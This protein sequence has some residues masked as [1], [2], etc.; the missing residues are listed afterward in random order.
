[1]LTK[2]ESTTKKNSLQ[3]TEFPEYYAKDSV[4]IFYFPIGCIF[5]LTSLEISK[6]I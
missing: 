1:M 3:K 5:L 2:Y 6:N 4:E